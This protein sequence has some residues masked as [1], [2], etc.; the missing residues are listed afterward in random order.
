[1]AAPAAEPH[2]GQGSPGTRIEPMCTADW[3]AVRR[4]YQEGIE[5]GN[6]TFETAV[7]EWEAWDAS[8]LRA[9]RLVAR[10]GTHIVGWGALSPVSSRCVYAGVAEVSVYV[11]AN[12][13]G[14]GIGRALLIALIAA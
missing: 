2:A 14:Q 4:I 9:C 6:A 3:P 1:M 5:T 7:P 12:A 11:A 10:Q 8:H 13:R